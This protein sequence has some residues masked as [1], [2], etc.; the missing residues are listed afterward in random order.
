MY[1]HKKN[2]WPKF[3]WD[4]DVITSLLGTVRHRTK[5]G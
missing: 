3:T 2:D 5:R 4:A 1:I